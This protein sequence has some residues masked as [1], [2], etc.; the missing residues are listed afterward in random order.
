MP[1]ETN[2]DE[3]PEDKEIPSHQ[4]ELDEKPND[5][6]AAFNEDEGMDELEGDRPSKEDLD[7]ITNEAKEESSTMPD[8]PQSPG[9]EYKFFVIHKS[10]GKVEILDEIQP[11]VVSYTYDP[12]AVTP[13]DI[14]YI[15]QSCREV[16]EDTQIEVYMRFDKEANRAF[17]WLDIRN[18]SD[19][20][21]GTM[22]LWRWK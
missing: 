21:I 2:I 4:E 18:R 5:L 12:E 9:S 7:N 3:T 16:L 15:A 13:R 19:I 1:G 22:E 6:S 20:S 10:T 8:E 11:G 14:Q 17:V